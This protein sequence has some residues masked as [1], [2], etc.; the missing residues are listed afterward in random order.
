MLGWLRLADELRR[1]ARADR[2]PQLWWRDDDAR[3]PS[4]ALDRLL[5]CAGGRPLALA[6]IPQEVDPA[7]VVR[8]RPHREICILQHGVD[9]RPAA[10]SGS[11][12]QFSPDDSAARVAHRLAAGWRRLAAFERRLPVYVPPWNHVTPNVLAA[13]EQTDLQAVSAWQAP[14]EPRRV[15]VHLD[16]LRW[17]PGPRFVGQA[18]FLGRLRR[19]LA[20]RRK[21]RRW[22]DP[23]GLL[24]H[25]LDHDE[26]AWR[27]LE[28]LM[29]WDPLRAQAWWR[30]ADEL[31]DLAPEIA[32]RRNSGARIP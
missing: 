10:P 18:L 26:A 9:H 24:T 5:H 13:L 12:S 32:S 15:D 17:R 8:L 6:V 21:A 3:G 28:R 22:D 16:L 2:R 25:H 20:G 29:G 1:W 14:P 27:F 30:G 7:L 4:P 11:P 31:F 23:I 19:M